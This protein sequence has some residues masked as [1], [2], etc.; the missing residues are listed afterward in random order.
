[1]AAGQ[2]N[3]GTTFSNPDPHRTLSLRR[4][5]SWP[6]APLFCSHLEPSSSVNAICAAWLFLEPKDLAT[7][8]PQHVRASWS[9]GTASRRRYTSLFL[10]VSASAYLEPGQPAALVRGHVFSSHLR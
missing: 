1:M 3:G 5:F 4:H 6:L 2:H 9:P 10:G 8:R 7:A